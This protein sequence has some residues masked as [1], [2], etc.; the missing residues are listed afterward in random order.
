LTVYPGVGYLCV[1][2]VHGAVIFFIGKKKGKSVMSEANFRFALWRGVRRNGT[3]SVARG[4][5]PP[6]AA[7]WY[8]HYER[9]TTATTTI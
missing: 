9:L 6:I 2:G 4:S 3:R 8:F 7:A 5:I 1:S